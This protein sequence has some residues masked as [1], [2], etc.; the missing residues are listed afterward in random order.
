MNNASFNRLV[1]LAL[2]GAAAPLAAIPAHSETVPLVQVAQAQSNAPAADPKTSRE[3]VARVGDTE[4]TADELRNFIGGFS[5][6]EQAAFAKDTALL[7][8][9][10]RQVLVNRLVLDEAIQKKWEQQPGVAAQLSRIREK[11]LTELY[12]QSVSTPPGSYPTDQELQKTFDANRSVLIAPRQYQLRQIFVAEPKGG[13]KA[14][15][16]KA[17][18]RL[19]EFQRKLK[20]TDFAT[21]AST[22]NDA[23]NGGDLGWVGEGQLRPEIS[24]HVTGL[25]K[26]AMSDPIRLD[27]GWHI[28]KLLDTKAAHPL[29]L[30]E[31]RDQLVQQMRTERAASIRR[32]YLA[33][34]LKQHPPVIN[35][36][37]L[38]K[39]FDSARK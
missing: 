8:Q 39:L 6:Q 17:K 21:V 12:L 9:A 4:V 35:E 13:D 11:A 33:Q 18:E 23:P 29:T 28:I 10:I 24:A 14:A 31:V 25:T 36:L 3:V 22:G 26:N 30:A 7:S 27:D 37:A 1:M 5:L 32:A 16:A 20:D 34:L 19:D 2:C 38:S 15:Q